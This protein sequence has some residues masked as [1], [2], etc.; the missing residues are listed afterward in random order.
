MV[1]PRSGCDSSSTTPVT[2]SSAMS[3]QKEDAHHVA[4][5]MRPSK[6]K[7]LL[8]FANKHLIE[9]VNE[10]LSAKN[11]PVEL[12]KQLR[13]LNNG[14]D[15]A[16]AARASVDILMQRVHHLPKAKKKMGSYDVAKLVLLLMN[17]YD[18]TIVVIEKMGAEGT[19]SSCEGGE[20]L[21]QHHQHNGA[22]PGGGQWGGSR[23]GHKQ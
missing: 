15:D 22:C 17:L 6:N 10:A 5:L 3:T 1:S 7:K 18:D 4:I 21:W 12:V 2:S 19:S 23:C 14:D 13:S 16:C 8:S 11:N 9:A 20:F